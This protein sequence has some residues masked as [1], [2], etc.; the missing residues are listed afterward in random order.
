MRP[1]SIHPRAPQSTRLELT[2]TIHI[3]APPGAASTPLFTIH[4][5]APVPLAAA[6]RLIIPTQETPSPHGVVR[7]TTHTQGPA[8]RAGLPVA[9]T[10]T[11]ATIPATARP[12]AI[13]RLPAVTSPD[14]PAYPA[15]FAMARLRS[16][17]P[18]LPATQ[19]LVTPSPGTTA[20]FTRTSTV[21]CTATVVPA[22]RSTIPAPAPTSPP[23]PNLLSKPGQTAP[24][25]PR[26][27]V[28]SAMTVGPAQAAAV[29]ADGAGNWQPRLRTR[30]SL[31]NESSFKQAA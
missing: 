19:E 29:G 16:P 5:R 26:S 22:P 2:A 11:P 24:A 25:R 10:L 15:T 6:A 13:I 4:I 31:F 28:R 20:T 14:K 8:H 12:P 21:I 30:M 7:G 17:V 3:P 18:A 23:A 27:P 1:A 9:P